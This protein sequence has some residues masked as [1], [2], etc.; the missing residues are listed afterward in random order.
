MQAECTAQGA[1]LHSLRAQTSPREEQQQGSLSLA[2][3]T[4]ATVEC[5]Q[6]LQQ[7]VHELQAALHEQQE[8]GQRRSEQVSR[9]NSVSPPFLPL[10]GRSTHF[11]SHCPCMLC[12][13]LS[14]YLMLRSHSV[15]YG[16]RYA[17]LRPRYKQLMTLPALQLGAPLPFPVPG[18]QPLTM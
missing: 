11:S 4:A 16:C 9:A 5:V 18:M 6:G 10:L 1:E 7:Q 12:S 13:G 17:R 3:T 14:A 8:M 15:P 2:A